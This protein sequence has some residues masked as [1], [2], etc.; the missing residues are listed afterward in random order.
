[1]TRRQIIA[2]SRDIDCVDTL[3]RAAREPSEHSCRKWKVLASRLLLDTGAQRK[4][5][6]V[7]PDV[8]SRSFGLV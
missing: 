7:S 5:T 3:M 6:H 2:Y 8:Y 4:L 1:M